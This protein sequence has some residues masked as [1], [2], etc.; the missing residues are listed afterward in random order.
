MFYLTMRCTE[1]KAVQQLPEAMLYCNVTQERFSKYC[2]GQA[3]N[4]LFTII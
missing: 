1:N 2:F 3:C 4:F